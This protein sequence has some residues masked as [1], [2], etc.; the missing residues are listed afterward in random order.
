MLCASKNFDL[1]VF[2]TKFDNYISI[3]NIET[4]K[5]TQFTHE[6]S[7]INCAT[8]IGGLYLLTGGGDSSV[9]VLKLPSLRVLHISSFHT[10]PITYVTGNAEVGLVVSLDRNFILTLENLHNGKLI[11]SIQME[12]SKSAPFIEV[13]KSG[14]LA[15]VKPDQDISKVYV[16]DQRGE[17]INEFE[18]KG[19]VV[20]TDKMQ[21]QFSVDVLALGIEESKTIVLYDVLTCKVIQTIE[22]VI[23]EQFCTI[24]SLQS[25]L[26]ISGSIGSYFFIEMPKE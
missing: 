20:R 25:V 2:G 6:I 15:Y 26:A 8:I 23:P 22:D 11:R 21:L 12:E 1:I 5:V 19:K 3:F 14:C 10:E 24:N 17:K 16:Y 9:R 7:F 18:V 4:Q 13:F